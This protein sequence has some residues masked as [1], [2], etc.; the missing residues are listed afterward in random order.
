MQREEVNVTVTRG[1]ATTGVSTNA[2]GG[3]ALE[4]RK[5]FTK[6][7]VGDVGI[8]ITDVKRHRSSECNRRWSRHWPMMIKKKNGNDLRILQASTDEAYCW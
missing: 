5:R 6:L 8:Q 7:S 3:E 4:F 1:P 2:H